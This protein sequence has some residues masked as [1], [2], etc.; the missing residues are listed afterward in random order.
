MHIIHKI[1]EWIQV[2][3][4]ISGILN[5]R[6]CE[7][8]KC[9]NKRRYRRATPYVTIYIIIYIYMEHNIMNY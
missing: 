6:K 4:N 9:F 5:R 8:L 1:P 2:K 7:L 3:F